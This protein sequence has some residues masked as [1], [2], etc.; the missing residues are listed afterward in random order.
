MVSR[1]NGKYVSATL[2]LEKAASENGFVIQKID[3]I[4]MTNI[5]GE[6]AGDMRPGEYALI[7]VSLFVPVKTPLASA[8][9]Q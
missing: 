7:D 1:I 9:R 2:D 4:K 5:T 6:H 8:L 3:G